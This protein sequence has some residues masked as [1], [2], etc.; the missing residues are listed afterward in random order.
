MTAGMRGLTVVSILILSRFVATAAA[1][2]AI[3]DA[4]GLWNCLPE[5]SGQPQIQ[6]DFN[7]KVYRR[8][9]QHICSTYELAPVEAADAGVRISF[10]GIGAFV[11]SAGGRRYTETVT[12]GEARVV[13]HG[14]CEHRAAD[15]GE[16]S[17]S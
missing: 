1:D 8:C 5:R 17:R 7:E 10:G 9:D 4:S 16:P 15:G 14:H 2:P 11:A 12:V 13:N 3:S 6:I